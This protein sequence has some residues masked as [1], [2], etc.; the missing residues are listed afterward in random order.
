MAPKSSL[1]TLR[2]RIL[3]RPHGDVNQNP[4][5]KASRE[6]KF[7]SALEL[8]VPEVEP[9]KTAVEVHPSKKQKGKKARKE[10]I[11]VDVEDN[12][13]SRRP[14]DNVLDRSFP[15]PEF[16]DKS[17]VTSAVLD[18]IGNDPDSIVDKFQ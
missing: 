17:L 8:S 6:P 16:M 4:G 14:E 10:V 9:L 12:Q 1:D 7:S 18:Q 5:S 15:Y 13:P 2:H 3:K 11:R